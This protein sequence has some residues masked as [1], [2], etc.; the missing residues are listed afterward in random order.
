MKQLGRVLLVA[1]VLFG[2]TTSPVANAQVDIIQP[3]LN[4]ALPQIS[5]GPGIN[6]IGGSYSN[7]ALN[8]IRAHQLALQQVQAAIIYLQANRDNILAGKNIGYNAAFGDFY[9]P[10]SQFAG[11]Y[12]RTLRR[13]TGSVDRFGNPEYQVVYNTAHFD[14]VLD[15]YMRIQ[16]ALQ[17]AITYALGAQPTL[18]TTGTSTIPVDTAFETYRH[19]VATVGDPLFGTPFVP[20]QGLIYSFN[21]PQGKPYINPIT[22][23]PFIDPLTGQPDIDP[24]T[25]KPF[26]NPLTGKPFPNYAMLG[27]ASVNN[28]QITLDVALE[29]GLV[30]WGDSTSFS[31]KHLTQMGTNPNNPLRWDDDNDISTLTAPLTPEQELAFFKDRLDAYAVQRTTTTTSG[32]TTTTPETIYIGG[33]FLNES[34]RSN[35][36]PAGEPNS[37]FHKTELNQYQMIIA[38]LAQSDGS[39][40]TSTT[41]NNVTTTSGVA[42][43]PGLLELFGQS[44][45]FFEAL[46]SKSYALF[47]DV[48]RASQDGGIGDA[49][50]LPPPGKRASASDTFT[51]VVPGS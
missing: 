16:Q 51:P 1:A 43:E 47:A 46:D 18:P 33:A 38:A 22:K 19:N 12:N 29:R 21:D 36:T 41:T 6:P 5:F 11:Q 37:F 28:Q 27:D 14:R 7:D 20:Q 44:A 4:L 32:V 42:I 40:Q 31:P 8:I 34:Q 50:L 24:V 26:L 15:V 35:S 3:T 25:G 23:K 30:Q 39:T 48:F 10:N 45:Y 2:T 13:P 49:S 9:D 17:N